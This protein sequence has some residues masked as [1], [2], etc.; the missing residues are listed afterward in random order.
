MSI[1]K[2]KETPP[3]PFIHQLVSLVPAPRQDE[4]TAAAN[5]AKDSVIKKRLLCTVDGA[6]NLSSCPIQPSIPVVSGIA[7]ALWWSLFAQVMD[8]DANDC[9]GPVVANIPLIS[10]W[11]PGQV[12]KAPVLLSFQQLL[13]KGQV[14]RSDVKGPSGPKR[15]ADAMDCSGNKLFRWQIHAQEGLEQIGKR[16]PLNEVIRS[17]ENRLA[18]QGILAAPETIIKKKRNHKGMFYDVSD[19]F[20]DDQELE[21]LNTLEDRKGKDRGAA[22]SA[23]TT[24]TAPE[25]PK[26]VAEISTDGFRLTTAEVSGTSESSGSDVEALSSDAAWKRV[27]NRGWAWQL[28]ELEKEM[29]LVSAPGKWKGPGRAKVV[30][31][32]RLRAQSAM[33]R[34][35]ARSP[36]SIVQEARD[37]VRSADLKTPAH[38]LR[39][40]CASLDSAVELCRANSAASIATTCPSLT[41]IS[42]GTAVSSLGFASRSLEPLQLRKVEA[43]FDQ[44]DM[45]RTRS[46]D[47]DV[48]RKS[49]RKSTRKSSTRSEASL[50]GGT[51][52]LPP[53]PPAPELQR[54]SSG[55]SESIGSFGS[56]LNGIAEA[57]GSAEHS[58]EV[59]PEFGE[60]INPSRLAGRSGA[61][62]QTA[63]AR[64]KELAKNKSKG[65]RKEKK[66]KDYEE[67]LKAQVESCRTETKAVAVKG[68]CFTWLRGELLGRGSLGSVWKATDK[69]TG[70]TMAVKEVIIDNLDDSEKDFSQSL[71]VEIDLYKQLKHPNIVSYLGNDRVRDRFYIYLEYMQGGS[72]SQV[73]HRDGPMSEPLIACYARQL[74]EG[75]NYL[76]TREP[77]ILHRDVKGGNILVGEKRPAR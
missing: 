8:R 6:P 43:D 22:T 42:R 48:V 19:N 3:V 25:E 41:S 76:H 4:L 26:V 73:L 14:P 56:D 51:A 61:Q 27:V 65:R 2:Q 45:V 13:A 24:G 15:P 1:D 28:A 64:L 33:E 74:L 11:E 38:R 35:E 29:V 75:L 57:D 5:A 7:D 34:P 59:D 72:V 31:C 49:T 21:T 47:D 16:D 62:L 66:E 12:P 39:S 70:K 53:A 63:L 40:S 30:C 44:S 67:R 18:R 20:I 23:G 10:P 46:R 58:G 50:P 9:A 55:Q 69:K 17:M 77:L 68:G 71:Q 32:V 60:V 36:L 52:E 37:F 54:Q